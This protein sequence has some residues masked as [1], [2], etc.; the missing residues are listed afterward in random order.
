MGGRRTLIPS[1]L[2][3]YFDLD[4]DLDPCIILIAWQFGFNPR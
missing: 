4:L 2:I 3:E 1:L